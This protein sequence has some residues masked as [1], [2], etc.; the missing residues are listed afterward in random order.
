MRV[1]RNARIPMPDGV[2]LAADLFMPEGA[3]PFPAILEYIPYRKD[4]L[5][6]PRHGYHHRFAEAGYVGVR[7]DVRGTGASE[8][9]N[10]D[11][12]R[13]VE[14]ADG[15]ELVEWLAAQPWS[16]GRVAMFGS[17]YGGFTA[18]QVAARRPPHLAAIVPVYATDDRYTDDIHYYGGCLGAAHDIG[19]YAT[20]MVASNALP[21]YPEVSGA[22]WAEL[23]RQHLEGSVPYLL[24][25]L[26]HP[27]DGPYWAN[28]SLRPGYERIACPTYLV[29]GW[30]DGYVTA[31]LRTYLNLGVPRKLLVG[32]WQHSRPDVGAPGPRVDLVDEAVGWLDRWCRDR[33]PA[34]SDAPPL[35]F[36][37]QEYDPPA[38]DRR[39]ATGSWRAE[40]T[41][42]V[43]GAQ[44]RVLLLSADGRL[45][46]RDARE[47]VREYDYDP[48]V[49][50]AGGLWAGMTPWLPGDQ[51]VEEA[52]SL[53]WTSAPLTGP[54]TILGWPRVMLHASSSA[55]VAAFVVRLADVA[56]DGA[57][58][59]VTK[60]ILNATRRDSR[61]DPAPLVPGAVYELA[62][63][64]AAT[65]WMFRP[66]HR[67]RLSVS[68]ADW[69]EVWPTPFPA[70]NGVACGAAHPSR[71]VL[72]VVPMRAPDS[73]VRLP[74]P[75][76][77]VPVRVTPL[78]GEWTVVHDALGGTCGV[79][80]R[81]GQ[82]IRLDAHT[83]VT[84]E[85]T[86]DAWTDRRRPADTRV[87][88]AHRITVRRADGVT[89][90]A[91]TTVVRSDERTFHVVIRLEVTVDGRPHFQRQWTDAVP[92]LLL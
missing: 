38:P 89:E 44:E 17:S 83:E 22:D 54:L 46:D 30:R 49:G 72:P 20:R 64:L 76:H 41:W 15:A 32:P 59:L 60:G 10:D 29:G 73:G 12:Y 33:A 28:G 13:E 56:P 47:G 57:S 77:V 65:A 84:L 58:A 36:Y 37:V 21:P 25:W 43:P 78:P 3:G 61:T 51:R 53:C 50:V 2:H 40:A 86:L 90:A 62:I 63:D 52:L 31:A 80:S 16:S 42:P 9:T 74:E 88:G 68:S 35:V 70:R 71:L 45:A 6:A 14:Q 91:A 19:G 81:G 79:R 8:G 55:E 7:A 66:G 4:D 87:T 24:T 34:G 39:Q 18:L 5:T 23:W 69:P 48:A 11:E 85:A 67:I 1:V 26:R 92:R 75:R 82:T 27:T